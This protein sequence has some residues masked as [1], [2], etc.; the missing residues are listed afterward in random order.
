[1]AEKLKIELIVD[2]KGSVTVKQFG[3][4][5]EQSVKKAGRSVEKADKQTQAWLNSWKGMGLIAGAAAGAVV[6]SVGRAGAACIA[7]ASDAE[8]T[9]SKFAVVFAGQEAQAEAWSQTLVTSYAMSTRES[10]QYLSSVQDLLVPMGMAA[11]KAGLMSNEVVKLSADLGSFNNLPTAKV[12]EDIQ[13]ALVGNYETMKKYGV[14]LNMTVV[15]EKALAMG[16]AE[17][18]DEL[19][20]G[21]KAQAAY[22]LMVEGSAA[23]IGDM[24]RTSEGYANQVKALEAGFE[25]LMVVVGEKLLPTMTKLVGVTADVVGWITILAGGETALTKHAE[26]AD[27]L[28]NAQR[29]LNNTLKYAKEHNI[30]HAKA[31]KY[32]K[33]QVDAAS[34]ALGR[35]AVWYKQVADAAENTGKVQETSSKAAAKL[36]KEREKQLENLQKALQESDSLQLE[37]IYN[38]EKWAESTK[39]AVAI[40]AAEYDRLFG[41]VSES[42]Q[43]RREILERFQ[44]DYA[45][46]TL[47]NY[48]LERMMLDERLAYYDMHIQD[49]SMLNEWYAAE[50][51]RIQIEQEMAEREVMSSLAEAWGL[52]HEEIRKG[53]V[54]A[55]KDIGAAV[56]SASKYMGKALTSVLMGTKTVGDAIKEL[57]VFLLQTAIE[58]L[59]KIGVQQL[60][61]A[62]TGQTALAASTAMTVG[63][64]AT[65]AAAAIPAAMAVSIASWGAAAAAGAAAY[66]VATGAM[67]GTTAAGIAAAKGMAATT[68]S[69]DEGG[70]STTPGIYYAGVPEAH[71]P[72]K[73]GSVPVEFKKPVEQPVVQLTIPVSVELD[74][75]V[76]GEFVAEYL[77]DAT[78]DGDQIIHVRGITDI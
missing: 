11:D 26:A 27:R 14:V 70:I 49:K 51:Q 56:A 67:L 55:W 44:D 43:Q 7:A 8:E 68:A 29:I 18:K 12:M 15:Q 1:M 57:G 64:M 47:E 17:T 52:T 74:G 4:T 42:D 73:Q 59:I 71:I 65:V 22:A 37:A 21:H 72:L 58:T 25:D 3:K 39:K 19:T 40:S 31:I 46:S 60:I 62:A 10:K 54:N 75:N 9:A 5:T 36:A 28:Y 38:N 41:S 23:A 48:E 6:Y 77:Y 20:A 34:I 13:S 33:E 50:A 30:E 61:L 66:G 32:A 63:A 76:V 35:Q 53:S 2:D 69:F 16:L 78:K 45:A 24:A